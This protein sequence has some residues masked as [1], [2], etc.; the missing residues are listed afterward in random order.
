MLHDFFITGSSPRSPLKLRFLEGDPK[1]AKVAAAKPYFPVNQNKH[2]S[3]EVKNI[4]GKSSDRFS[5]LSAGRRQAALP[6]PATSAQFRNTAMSSGNKIGK[7]LGVLV[8]LLAPSIAMSLP[9]E[10]TQQ[11]CRQALAIPILTHL[12]LRAPVLVLALK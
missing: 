10:A 2:I 5:N 8:L 12:G 3:G 6:I 1:L 11:T 4:S 9:A 7:A